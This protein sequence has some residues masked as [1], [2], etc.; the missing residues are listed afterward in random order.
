[1]SGAGADSDWLNPVSGE[2]GAPWRDA[3]EPLI[4]ITGFAKRGGCLSKRISLGADGAIISDGSACVMARGMAKRVP[5]SS[6]EDFADLIARLDPHEA[7]ALGALRLGLPDEVEI[8][9][10]RHLNGNGAANVVART[11]EY[12]SYRPGEPALALIDFDRKGMPADVA[13]RVRE[14]GGPKA[15]IL[16]VIPELGNAG[17][18]IRASTSSGLCRSD[19]G[20]RF[21]ASGGAHWFVLIR[22]GCD[23]ERYLKTLHDRCWL[24]Q[25]GWLMVGGGGQLLERSLVDRNVYSPERLVFEAAPEVV[26]PLQQDCT[27]RAPR[28]IPGEPLDTKRA[29]PDLTPAERGALQ[30]SLRAARQQMAPQAAEARAAFVERHAAIVAKRLSVPLPEARRIIE[31]Q[32]DGVLLPGIALLFDSEDLAGCTVSDV[33]AD[34]ER[35]IGATLADP[36][37]GPAYG[38]GKAKVLKRPDGTLFIHSFA[39]GRT[40]FELRRDAANP[41]D[42]ADECEPDPG[43]TTEASVEEISA[44]VE[45]LVGLSRIE[46]TTTRKASAKKLGISVTDL[47]KAVRTERGHINAKRAA[48]ARSSPQPQPG[49][50]KWPHGFEMRADGLYRLPSMEGD[51]DTWV[52]PPFEVLGESRDPG[53]DGWGLWLR[54]ADADGRQHTW[55]MSKR[56]LMLTQGDLEAEL[57]DKGLRVSPTQFAKAALRQALGEVISGNRVTTVARPGWHTHE[58]GAYC[59]ILPNGEVIGRAIGAEPLVLR[60]VSETADQQVSA[61]GTLEEWKADVAARMAGNDLPA[62][63]LCCGFAAPLLDVASESSGGFHLA[64]RSK[65]GK[66]LTARGAVSIW[67]PPRGGL[68]RSWRTTANALEGIAEESNDLVTGLDEI[69][70]GDPREV[71]GGVYMLSNESGKGRMKRDATARRSRTWRTFVLST[72]ELDVASMAQKAGQSLPAGA[73]V[74]LPSLACIPVSMWTNLHGFPTGRDLMAALQKAVVKQHGVAGRAFMER[75]VRERNE[76]PEGLVDKILAMQEVFSKILP[77]GADPQVHDVARRFALVAAAGEMAISWG[78]LPWKQDEAIRACKAVLSRWIA[79]RGGSAP[80]EETQHVRAVRLFLI[81]HGAARFVALR[82]QLDSNG[83]ETGKWEE[84]FPDR[85]VLQRSGWRRQADD[86]RDEYLIP[87]EIWREICAKAQIDPVETARTLHKGGFIQP[88]KDGKNLSRIERVPVIGPARFYVIKPTLLG[89]E[90]PKEGQ[91]KAA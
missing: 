72:G 2:S 1:M 30:Q 24:H 36:L 26:H 10:K 50:T 22:D 58:D 52:C 76:D 33:L 39:H 73:D 42:D 89:E 16:S 57:V 6:L 46:Y 17:S 15:A 7:I 20:E 35:F 83:N 59:F 88:A 49:D 34:P 79:S 14:L 23:A 9:T 64:G 31:K 8:T 12:F 74:R 71:A 13:E 18:V 85:Q 45:R 40:D 86:G 60:A 53:G 90:E 70:Q 91:E 82:K 51:A 5:L 54:W 44:E 43:E 25:L 55:L 84:R 66:T 29:C 37:E 62:V 27:A 3:S 19:T 68:L 38:R 80:A 77:A 75:L 81:E 4:E 67:G 28:V 56:L 87:P 48:E 11:S 47:D 41:D 61:S 78:M 63:V 32:C 65:T 69:H 21:V